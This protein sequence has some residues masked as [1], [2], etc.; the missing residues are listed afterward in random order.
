[1]VCPPFSP[2]YSEA[3]WD[4]SRGGAAPKPPTQALVS[5]IFVFD[6]VFRGQLG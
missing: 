1:M 5:L 6:A 4:V 2:E 3:G